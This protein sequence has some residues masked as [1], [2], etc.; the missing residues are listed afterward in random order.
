MIGVSNDVE[1]LLRCNRLEISVLVDVDGLINTEVAVTYIDQGP[2]TRVSLVRRWFVSRRTS[3]Y[4]RTP[5]GTNSV[6]Q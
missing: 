6:S 1:R 5:P 3:S 4:K 2:N